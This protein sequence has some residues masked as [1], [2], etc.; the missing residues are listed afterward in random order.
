MHDDN[1]DACAELACLLQAGAMKVQ[2]WTTAAQLFAEA[3]EVFKSSCPPADALR[4]THA[5]HRQVQHLSLACV[6]ATE[7]GIALMSADYAAPGGGAQPNGA[8]KI[9]LQSTCELLRS[10][11]SKLLTHCHGTAA[12]DV[13][14]AEAR[15]RGF[16][17]C[18]PSPP[19]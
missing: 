6:E 19:L 8:T 15:V 14:A 11:T 4:V 18:A 5:L 13:Q 16:L 2:A 3:V 17:A 7:L 9:W 1:V 12:H 10:S